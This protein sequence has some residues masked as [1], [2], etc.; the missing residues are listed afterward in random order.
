MSIIVCPNCEMRVK[1]PYQTWRERRYKTGLCAR[2][3]AKKKK[4]RSCCQACLDKM[5]IATRERK[6][7]GSSLH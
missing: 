1:L 4:G 3:P 5:K 6:K 7:R 2:C